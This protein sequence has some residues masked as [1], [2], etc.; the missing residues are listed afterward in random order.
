M[1]SDQYLLGWKKLEEEIDKKSTEGS[2]EQVEWK[3]IHWPTKHLYL[4]VAITVD[5]ERG[6]DGE[7]SGKSRGSMV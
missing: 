7:G 6:T 4:M 3:R 5:G 1:R 2:V